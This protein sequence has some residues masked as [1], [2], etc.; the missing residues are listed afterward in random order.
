MVDGPPR[1]EAGGLASELGI[2][3]AIAQVL[4]NRG[5]FTAEAARKFLFG[6]LDS[7]L[8]PYLFNDM[9]KAVELSRPRSSVEKRS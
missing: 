9:A 5:V 2:P 8:D 7:L 1:P 3:P 6:G 4:T